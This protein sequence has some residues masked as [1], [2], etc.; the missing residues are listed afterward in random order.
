[1]IST[2]KDAITSRHIVSK[3]E[4]VQYKRVD[5]QV[6]FQGGTTQKYFPMNESLLLL[7]YLKNSK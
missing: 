6:L 3:T 5:Y 7:I 2:I 4:G 1:M